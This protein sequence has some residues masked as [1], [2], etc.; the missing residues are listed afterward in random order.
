MN[1]FIILLFTSLTYSQDFVFDKEKGRAVPS[2]VGQLKLMKGKVYRKNAEGIKEVELGERFKKDDLLITDDKSFARILIVDD[3]LI[4]VGPKSELRFDEIDFIDK[5]NRKLTFTLLK[6]QLSGDIKNKAK[7][8]EIKFKT[9]YTSMGVRGTY[10]LMNHQNVNSLHIAEYALVSGKIEITD[11][12][13]N[14]YPII[15]GE[16]IVLI[17]DDLRKISAEN[18]GNLSEDEFIRLEGKT[19]DE[20]SEFKPLL[21]YFKLSEA[22]SS[23]PLYQVLNTSESPQASPSELSEKRKEKSFSLD[24]KLKQLNQKLKENRGN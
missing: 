22:G 12:Q 5:T 11:D 20:A 3:S 17:H 15:K 6:G 21:P 9:R 1:I 19:I 7:P 14:K 24:E 13:N 4:S 8:G 23:S 2:Y 18:K 10:L 16:K